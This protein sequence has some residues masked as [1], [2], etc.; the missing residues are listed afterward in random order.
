[1]GFFRASLVKDLRR[2]SRDPIGLALALSLP[3]IIPLLVGA[4][5][6]NEDAGPRGRLLLVD[7]DDSFLSTAMRGGTGGT[8]L[9]EVLIVERVGWREG[10]ERMD[11][12]EASAM[13]V[14]PHGFQ[15]AVLLNQPCELTLI[16]N[17][18]QRIMPRMIRQAVAMLV[19]AQFYAH[20]LAGEE[21][22]AFA[23]G[24]PSNA[25]LA[26]SGIAAGELARRL[27]AYLDP[28]LITL[29]TAEAGADQKKKGMAALFFP[30]M[31]I[32]GAMF[33]AQTLSADIWRERH[34]GALR[35]IR[36]TPSPLWMVLA[37]K[38]VA[39]MVFFGAVAIGSLACGYWLIGATVERP[40]LAFL[41]V[42]LTGAA[43]YMAMLLVTLYASTER[44]ANVLTSMVV[45]VLGFIGGTF[46]PFES[47]PN[48]L[49]TIGEWTPNGWAVVRFKELLDG[50]ADAAG[51]GAAALGLVAFGSVMFVLTLRRLRVF[52]LLSGH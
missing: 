22:E 1:M 17:P 48:W 9:E 44:G 3:V 6:D 27:D 32:L 52:S 31:V 50:R 35:R 24:L 47:M 29:A 7:H 37:S 39:A 18:S 40:V 15:Q 14:V 41:W 49:R 51:L 36:A 45:F 20:E 11:R 38:G 25:V 43:M 30:G 4:V 16:T 19:E 12:G 34:S 42:V 2:M 10:R 26:R 21:L 28:P 13:L 5:F 23:D 8:P 46:F 33:V